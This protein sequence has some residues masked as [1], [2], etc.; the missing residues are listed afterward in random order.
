MVQSKLIEKMARKGI[1]NSV[2]LTRDVVDSE[3]KIML[4]EKINNELE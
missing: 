3:V 4:N 2:A 1:S